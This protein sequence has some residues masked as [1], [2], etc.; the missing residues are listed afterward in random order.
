MKINRFIALVVFAG[1]T[2]SSCIGLPGFGMAGSGDV[3]VSARTVGAFDTIDTGGSAEVR[4]HKG[5]AARV[6]VSTDANLQEYYTAATSGG[7]LRLG[8]ATGT[9]VSRVT[10]LVVDVYAPDIESVSVSGSGD[11]TFVDAFAGDAFAASVSGSGSVQGSLRFETVSAK[12]SGSG[13]ILL[14]GACETLDLTVS[15]SGTF[16]GRGMQASSVTA[17]LS[18]SGDAEVFATKRLDARLSGSGQIRYDGS[19]VVNASVSG[20]GSI[21]HLGD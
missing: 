21:R 4:V 5:P 16:E 3:V 18:G 14:T 17:T 10:R 11:M 6:V 19:P 15:G 8:F 2:L 1:M 20:S 7:V 12:I 13:S 9:S